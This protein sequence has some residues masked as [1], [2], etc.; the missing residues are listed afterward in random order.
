MVN[1]THQ[2][3]SSS[4]LTYSSPDE[5][6]HLAFLENRCRSCYFNY[7]RLMEGPVGFS[8]GLAESRET[9]NRLSSFL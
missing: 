9:E 1:K 5:I 4:L 6:G 8:L 7:L 3:I 2:M